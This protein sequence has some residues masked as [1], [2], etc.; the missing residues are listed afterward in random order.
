MCS[1]ILETEKT[2]LI[3]RNNIMISKGSAQQVRE[4]F[5]NI[6]YIFI[7][8]KMMSYVDFTF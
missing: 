8:H 5:K 2:D 3:E 1:L 6:P 7:F 4:K